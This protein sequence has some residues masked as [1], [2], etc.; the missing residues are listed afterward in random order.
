[1]I[2]FTRKGDSDM[3]FDMNIADASVMEEIVSGSNVLTESE[4][5]N[6]VLAITEYACSIVTKT[7]GPYGKTTNIDDSTFTAPTKDGWTVLRNLRFSDPLYNSIYNVINQ[8]SFDLVTKV[9]D[10]TTSALTGANVFLHAILAKLMDHESAL[11]NLRQ[12]DILK[13]IEDC[14]DKIIK[15][16][17]A[18]PEIRRIDPEDEAFEDIRKIAYISS[19]GNDELSETIQNIYKATKNPNIYVTLDAGDS[20]EYEIQE[21]YKYDGGV[22]NHKVYVNSEN[23]TYM[24]DTPILVA[25]FNHNVTYNEHSKIISA[26]SKYATQRNTSVLIIA[27]YFDDIISNILATTIN[28]YVQQRQVPNVI[29]MQCGMATMADKLAMSD[30]VLLTNGQMFDYGKVRAL[31]VTM[32]NMDPKNVQNKIEDDLLDI[33]QYN[34]ENPE[35][36]IMQCIGHINR[37]V[38][39]E[40]YIIIQ[41]YETIVNKDLYDQVIRE[42]EE[43]F[44]EISRRTNKSSNMLSKDYMQAQ[45]RYIKMLGKMGTIKVGGTTEL[46]KHCLK[47]SVDDAVLACRSAFN[48]GYIRGLNLTTINEINCLIYSLERETAE[49]KRDLKWQREMETLNMFKDVFVE[50]SLY[51]LRN[52]YPDVWDPTTGSMKEQSYEVTNE[53]AYQKKSMKTNTELLNTAAGLNMTFDLVTDTITEEWTVINSLATDVEILNSMVG[54]LSL[55]LTSDQFVSLNK[56]YDKKMSRKIMLEREQEKA[57][58]IH[59]GELEAKMEFIKKYTRITN[60]DDEN[61]RALNM[62]FGSHLTI[63]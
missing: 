37:A 6:I 56:S 16:L 24:V 1:M 45:Q 35:Q 5:K 17:H 20:L 47:D 62:I 23:G 29:C 44:T 18:S 31:N 57:K 10:G 49:E 38:I 61:L 39:G 51:V 63:E 58:A 8:I 7:L 43:E 41:N 4:Y 42:I 48:N 53:H 14:K 12:S 34:F 52:K 19:N 27:P 25:V 36:M 3:K 60:L 15:A 9:G 28:S 21:G 40:K 32:H 33:E 11:Y 55:F 46:A 30:L 50:M 26:L 59:L 22:L 2:K 13:L 54:V